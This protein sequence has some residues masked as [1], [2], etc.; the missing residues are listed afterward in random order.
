MSSDRT[1]L[2]VEPG[3]MAALARLPLF[4]SLHGKRAVIAGGGAAAAWKAEL[5]AAAGA[6]VAVYADEISSAMTDLA[7]DPVYGRGR[8]R[9]TRRTWRAEDLSGAAIAIGEFA[10]EAAAAVFCTAARTGGVPVNVIDRPAFCDFSF[11]AVVNRSPLVVGIS[12]DGAAPA[13]AQAIRSTVEAVLPAGFAAWAAAAARW[14]D[15]VKHSG[16]SFAGRRRFWQRFAV[17][18]LRRSDRPPGEADLHRLMTGVDAAMAERGTVTTVCVDPAQPDLLTLR[19]VRALRAADVVIFDD[20][21]PHETLDFAR[22]EARKIRLGGAGDGA[23]RS[24]REAEALA[25]DL[26]RQGRRVVVMDSLH[27]AAGLAGAIDPG[28]S[29]AA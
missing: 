23:P 8:V 27:R 20:R 21:V 25:A 12:T 6:V 2:R 13:F 26:A 14:R 9:V 15:A 3:R 16:L 1:T 28:L 19:A 17:L 18:A 4:F 10:D 7:A 24:R 5:L 11:G 22:R 29:S